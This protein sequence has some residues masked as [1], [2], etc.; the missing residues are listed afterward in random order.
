MSDIENNSWR[1]FYFKGTFIIL[2]GFILSVFFLISGWN[3][4]FNYYNDLPQLWFQRCG[5][6]MTAIL[7]LS[8]YYVFKLSD[9]VKTVN[10][11]PSFALKTKDAYRPY[12]RV[13]QFV[14]VFL[15]VFTTVIWGYGDIVYKE[16][17]GV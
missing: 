5:S 16:I 12:I 9:D 3:G 2:V 14:A 1:V 8:D 17:V 13:F 7:L 6:I 4:W 10:M 11:V 15:T